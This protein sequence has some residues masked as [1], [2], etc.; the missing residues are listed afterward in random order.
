V[1]MEKGAATC[2][3]QELASALVTAPAPVRLSRPEFA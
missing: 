2:R 3:P 1:V